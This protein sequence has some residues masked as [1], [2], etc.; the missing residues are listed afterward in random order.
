M[1]DR[2]LESD[3]GLGGGG[4]TSSSTRSMISASSSSSFSRGP[5]C[6]P[7]FACRSIS[8]RSAAPS[9]KGSEKAS[10]S[11][12]I[13]LG[14]CLLA[15]CCWVVV[16]RWRL[17]ARAA[18]WAAAAAGRDDDDDAPAK[19]E[20]AAAAAARLRVTTGMAAVEGSTGVGVWLPARSLLTS[21]REPERS[22]GLEGLLFR[23]RRLERGRGEGLVSA[24]L[25]SSLSSL[26]CCS[27]P[28]LGGIKG[29]AAGKGGSLEGKEGSAKLKLGGECSCGLG[30]AASRPAKPVG[31]GGEEKMGPAACRNRC[32]VTGDGPSEGCGSGRGNAGTWRRGCLA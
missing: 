3:F 28:C 12:G 6:E 19:D 27:R 20:A 21:R 5:F 2:I 31:G 26:V 8:S 13:G 1:Y 14:R 32:E 4:G 15:G 23:G 16:V 7:A 18:G 9:S 24:R 17:S 25:E 10:E 22:L 29:G 30:R 11:I